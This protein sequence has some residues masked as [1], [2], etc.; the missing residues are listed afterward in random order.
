MSIAN[1]L[2]S[3][4]V[5]MLLYGLCDVQIANALMTGLLFYIGL[6]IGDVARAI[7]RLKD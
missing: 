2:M 1:L 4:G 3:L 6:G 7:H 5:T